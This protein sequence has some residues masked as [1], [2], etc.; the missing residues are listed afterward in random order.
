MA[1]RYYRRRNSNWAGA[2]I[3]D[4]V[5]VGNRLPWWG[6]ALMGVVMF[7]LLYWVVPAWVLACSAQSRTT[8]CS[9]SS[10][11]RRRTISGKRWFYGHDSGG[12]I[13]LSN[14]VL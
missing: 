4:S 11:D 1:R 13:S 8:T 14:R 6:A 12:P 10:F 3:R 7:S 2:L 5:E 9:R